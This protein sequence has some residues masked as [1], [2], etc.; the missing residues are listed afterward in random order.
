MQRAGIPVRSIL[1]VIPVCALLVASLLIMGT[2]ATWGDSR[3]FPP[4][5]CEGCA[6]PY[7]AWIMAENTW[8]NSTDE[9]D[10][11]A[12]I[13]AKILAKSRYELCVAG[14]GCITA[15]AH[16][17]YVPMD[18]LTISFDASSSTGDIKSYS[19]SFGDSYVE[20]AGPSVQHTYDRAGSYGVILTVNAGESTE[21]QFR[22]QVTVGQDTLQITSI[23]PPKPLAFDREI[24]W[25]L[26][27]TG[28]SS[29]GAASMHFEVY[30]QNHT[31]LGSYGMY[32]IYWTA[33]Y[34]GY[35][36]D[37]SIPVGLRIPS[38]TTGL[39]FKAYLHNSDSN[40]QT[41]IAEKDYPFETLEVVGF[42]CDAPAPGKL[43]T[44]YPVTATIVDKEENGP[45]RYMFNTGSGMFP[46]SADWAAGSRENRVYIE[47][48]HLMYA[49][50]TWQSPTKDSALE[51]EYAK[52]MIQVTKDL[53][54][55]MSAT[56]VSTIT[57]VGRVVKGANDLYNLYNDIGTMSSYAG[58]SLHAMT[59]G[60]LLR[61]VMYGSNALVEGFQVTAG[62]VLLLPK[63]LA[64]AGVKEVANACTDVLNAGIDYAQVSWETLTE[65]LAEEAKASRVIWAS[66]VVRVSNSTGAHSG[67]NMFV[68][69]RY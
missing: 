69:L 37:Q 42:S 68:E 20:R 3:E 49:T 9:D 16:F 64:P 21:S 60:E 31:H 14:G 58:K 35:E 28:T 13:T 53:A 55:N 24:Q 57:V 7:G 40:D 25:Q 34:G 27:F 36:F 17:E 29:S 18:G 44:S 62:G 15:K 56:G 1:S 47:R 32:D 5:A 65:A 45:W 2:L 30:D 61:A 67:K 10:S 54:R 11:D 23:T 33:T 51:L 59:R 39:T 41:A 26:Q 66:I 38:G 43:G 63:A 48:D 8:W 46:K 52:N 19:W 6:G 50:V 22:A 12:L 4:L